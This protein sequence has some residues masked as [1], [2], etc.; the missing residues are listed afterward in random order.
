MNR[1]RQQWLLIAL[2]FGALSA[3]AQG[4]AKAD[5]AFYL[6]DTTKTPVSDRMWHTYFE[7][8]VKFYELTIYSS[9]TPLLD[10]PTFA[11]ST[12]WQ[13]SEVI[14]DAGFKS[15]KKSSLSELL[16][17]LKRFA[18]QDKE[19]KAELKKVFYLYVIEP[20]SKGYAIVKTQLVGSGAKKTTD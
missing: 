4:V 8:L 15:I 7:G 9:C 10:R 18:E 12:K 11:Y 6:L 19:T 5:S 2:I 3:K 17:H 16:L 20:H 14:D 1:S 13:K